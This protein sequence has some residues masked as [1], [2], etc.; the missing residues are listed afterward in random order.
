LCRVPQLKCFC[1]F[2]FSQCITV[3]FCHAVVWLCCNFGL[4]ITA[5]VTSLKLFYV[6][7]GYD[8]YGWPLAGIPSWYFTYPHRYASYSVWHMVLCKCVFSP[9]I[10][11]LKPQSNGPSYSNTVI[12][13]LT[14]DGWAVTFGTARMGLCSLGSRPVPSSLYQ[15]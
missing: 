9:S 12:G 10:P 5:L 1:R 4:M 8:W 2:I 14:V 15:M 3:V 7:L 6:E 13:T 11:T